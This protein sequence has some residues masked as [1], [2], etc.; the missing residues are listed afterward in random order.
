AAGL[1]VPPPAAPPPVCPLPFAL[2]HRHVAGSWCMPETVMDSA[3]LL[4][5]LVAFPTVSSVSNLD[6]ITFVEGWL[7]G[8][9]F[10][11]TR[12]PDET[13]RKA[14]LFATLGPDTGGGI[15]LSGHS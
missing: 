4:E 6:L 3:D 13:G 10:R 2:D 9:G 1:S 11:L 12:I 15:L 8:R 14:N 5:R 7:G